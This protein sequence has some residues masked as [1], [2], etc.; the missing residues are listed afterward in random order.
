MK[1]ILNQMNA[2]AFS[3]E[4][5][6]DAIH[7]RLDTDEGVEV[8]AILV[9]ALMNSPYEHLAKYLK[10][11]VLQRDAIREINRV[12]QENAPMLQ[13][14]VAQFRADVGYPQLSSAL[15]VRE[16]DDTEGH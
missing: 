4:G 10:D 7:L 15:A 13:E 8:F 16:D 11:A 2:V 9:H 12:I 1:S 14:A 3:A 6:R 5:E